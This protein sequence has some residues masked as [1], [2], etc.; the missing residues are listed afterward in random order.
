MGDLP[1]QPVLL[2]LAH[3]AAAAQPVSP[4]AST[5][6]RERRRDQIE[7]ESGGRC[8]RGAI[9]VEQEDASTNDPLLRAFAAEQ[10]RSSGLDLSVVMLELMKHLEPAGAAAGEGKV[11][12][13][14]LGGPGKG[15]VGEDLP[16]VQV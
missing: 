2:S 3:A 6:G 13:D 12:P 11:G 10:E 9:V 4:L 1:S 5:C 16:H 15:G 8:D 7:T 14:A